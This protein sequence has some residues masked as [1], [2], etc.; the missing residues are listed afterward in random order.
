MTTEP[1]QTMLRSPIVTSG[2]M[3]TPKPIHVRRST[4]IGPFVPKG[5]RTCRPRLASVGIILHGA[6]PD[7]QYRAASAED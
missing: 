7:R 4:Q 1:A 2:S 3:T 6:R 5:L